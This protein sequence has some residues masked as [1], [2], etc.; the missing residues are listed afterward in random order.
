MFN[1][2][3]IEEVED[4]VMWARMDINTLNDRTNKLDER[5]DKLEQQNCVELRPCPKCK[6]D[7]LQVKRGGMPAHFIFLPIYKQ[8]HY[9]CTVCG[10]SWI[11][12]SETVQEEY[13]PKENK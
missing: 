5:V 12:K 9:Y 7:T 4:R 3:K 8:A 11:V 1:S 6:H 2:K 10:K 13:I